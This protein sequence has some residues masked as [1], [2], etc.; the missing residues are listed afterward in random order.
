M[1]PRQACCDHEKIDCPGE[2]VLQQKYGCCQRYSPSCREG[3]LYLTCLRPALLAPAKSF[4]WQ[5]LAVKRAWKRSFLYYRA[6]GE[7]GRKCI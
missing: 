2:L 4:H 7:K 3:E 5:E 1:E 6:G